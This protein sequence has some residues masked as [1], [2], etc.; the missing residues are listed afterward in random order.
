VNREG[1]KSAEWKLDAEVVMVWW[2]DYMILKVFSN[3]NESMIL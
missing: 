3:R 2:W 1:T